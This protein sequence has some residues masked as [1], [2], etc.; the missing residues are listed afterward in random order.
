MT[1]PAVLGLLLGWSLAVW[2]QPFAFVDRTQEAG[3]AQ[4]NTAGGADKRYIIEA[5]GCGAAF[6]DYD[7]DG[8]LDLYVVDGATF[9]TY[10][11]R[12]GPANA[13]YRNKGDGTF[14]PVK[15]AADR[16]W[17]AGV[18][19]GDVDND[20]YRD[21]YVTNYGAN[22]LYRNQGGTA[23]EDIT[24]AAGVGG[25]AYSASAAFFDYDND[26]DLDL[27]T[28]NYVVFDIEAVP[29]DRRDDE[30]CIYLGGIK[31]YCGPQG[32]EGAPDVLYRND[33]AA[34]TDVTEAA[35]IAAA[36]SYYGLGVVPADYDDDGDL[37]VFVANDETANVLFA[38]NG[39]GTFADVAPQ[40]GVAFNGDGRSRVG[41]G[42]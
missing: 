33:G 37:D 7:N 11:D 9:A 8:W 39:D 4:A 15:E 18:A 14:A 17:G 23:F 38:N 34:F 27:Y 16:G 26:G 32:M 41:Y 31:V 13:L 28:V 12:S 40:V 19:V 35:G 20:G 36:N 22:V 25:E 42:R 10:P 24:A 6:F 29:A 5:N 21:L 1:G 30:R 3:L 2:A